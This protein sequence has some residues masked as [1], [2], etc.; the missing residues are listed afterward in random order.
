MFIIHIL[1]LLIFI[2]I[3]GFYLK[4][5]L[6]DC[7]PAAVSLLILFLYGLSFG[8]LLWLTDILAPLFLLEN[9]QKKEKGA[10]LLCREGAEGTRFSDSPDAAYGCDSVCI[11]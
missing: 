6:T 8:N 4:E 2:L 1:S 7:I 10:C 9:G 3:L 11:R 5:K